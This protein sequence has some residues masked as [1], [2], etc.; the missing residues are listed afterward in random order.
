MKPKISTTSEFVSELM[1]RNEP[2][3]WDLDCVVHSDG[4]AVP[5]F[6]LTAFAKAF[7]VQVL[8]M[9]QSKLILF[10]EMRL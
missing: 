5:D 3:T 10:L 9:R 8:G 6:F 1:E 7:L 2:L 4:L